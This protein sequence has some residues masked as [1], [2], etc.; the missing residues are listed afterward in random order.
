M[1]AKS[2]PAFFSDSNSEFSVDRD[3]SA[4]AEGAVMYQGSPWSAVN[5]GTES[6]R[7][8][9]RVRVVRTSG[10]KIMIVKVQ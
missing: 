2:A 9:D 7:A 4:G 1:A 10:I 3:I 5:D 8:G 6:I